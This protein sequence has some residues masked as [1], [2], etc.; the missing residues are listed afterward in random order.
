MSDRRTDEC[1]KGQTYGRCFD[2]S[3]TTRR[4]Y[5][6]ERERVVPL[7]NTIDLCAC[8]SIGESEKFNMARLLFLY[9]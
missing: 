7:Q 6:Y 4:K 9:E 3:I 8:A 5:G 1:K 2:A